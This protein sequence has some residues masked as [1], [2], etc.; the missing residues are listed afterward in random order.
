MVGNHA[1][2]LRLAQ[3]GQRHV[4]HAAGLGEQHRAHRAAAASERVHPI[5]PQRRIEQEILER[6]EVGRR[7]RPRRRIGRRHPVLGVEPQP[8]GAGGVPVGTARAAAAALLDPPEQRAAA[9]AGDDDAVAGAG[10][11]GSDAVGPGLAGQP[12]DRRRGRLGP[13]RLE[14]G[15]A[16]RRVAGAH[17][18]SEVGEIDRLQAA[19]E[20]VDARRAAA[21]EPGGKPRARQRQEPAED[22]HGD[23]HRGRRHRR[24]APDIGQ[25]RGEERCAGQP[26]RRRNARRG[27][28]PELLS[29]MAPVLAHVAPVFQHSAQ[30]ERIASIDHRRVFNHRVS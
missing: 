6:V 22:Q 26:D 12:V 16:R 8:G 13:E 17:P 4:A 9:V 7:Q 30:P 11:L 18:A 27:G 25:R 14:L 24:P 10:V 19:L 5:G 3:R 2:D 15:P 23:R 28:A 29:E 1:R 21:P 20:I